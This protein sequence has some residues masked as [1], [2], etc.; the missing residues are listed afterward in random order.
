MGRMERDGFRSRQV[1]HRK[2]DQRSNRLVSWVVLVGIFLP[3]IQFDVAGLIWTPGRLVTILFLALAV[4]AIAQRGR[5]YVSDFLV[6]LV[7][8]WSVG[9]VIINGGFRPYV[10]VEALE[11]LS[12]YLIG[13]AFFNSRP[14]LEQ[15]IRVL[16]IV[17]IVLILL[18][19]LDTFSGRR[20]TA[21]AV[22]HVFNV[23]FDIEETQFR[24]GLVRATSTFPVSE[25]YGTFCAAAASIFLYSERTT[26]GKMLYGGLCI[27][28]CFLSVSSGPILALLIVLGTYFYGLLT[29][30]YAWRWKALRNSLIGLLLIIFLG[31]SL[32]LGNDAVHPIL[33]IVRNFTFDPWTGYF[34]VE[35]WRHAMVFINDNP[36]LGIGFNPIRDQNDIFLHSLDSLYLVIAWRFGI[37]AAILLILA[38]IAS[39]T[40]LGLEDTNSRDSYMLDLRTGFI[41]VVASIATVALTVH[42]WDSTW[43][44]W[45][46]CM[47]ISASFKEYAYSSR[48]RISARLAAPRR[49][50]H[51]KISGPPWPP[52]SFPVV[53]LGP[54]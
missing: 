38:I 26:I 46:I 2:F 10:L 24:N 20:F 5:F 41:L 45:S 22:A 6:L 8:I 7:S 12:G 33:W 53:D 14:K 11:L 43:I 39:I 36:L 51:A 35:E 52:P 37:P 50:P 47:G 27:F 32:V 23:P 30:R 34:R 49:T 29:R 25:L 48:P 19:L 42:F 3:P 21:E 13:R 1:D 18:A 31:D 16:K 44:F 54:R 15:F 9:S 17:S 28:G 40:G 4:W